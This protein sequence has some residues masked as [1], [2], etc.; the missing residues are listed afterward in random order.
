M[1]FPVVLKL[2]SETITHKSDVGGVKLNLKNAKEVATAYLEIEE[3]VSKLAGAEHFDGVTVQ[4]MVNRGS[5]YE[6]ILGSSTDPQFGP[7]LLFGTGGQLVEIFKDSALAIPPLTSTLALRMMEKT[8]IFEALHGVR[9]RKPVDISAL[10]NILIDFSRMVV[11]N[12][13][14]KECDINP[15]FVS[16]NEIIALDARV[17]L[18]ESD[19]TDDDLPQLAIRPYPLHHVLNASLKD[20]TPIIL[21]PIRPEDEP[22]IV[23]FHR[24][25]SENSVRQR[26]FEFMS[27]DERVA[28]ERLIRICFTDYDREWTL[29]AEIEGKEASQIIGVGRL[30]LVPGTRYAHFALII[31][32]NYHNLGLGTCLLQHLMTIAKQENIEMI[33]ARILSENVNMI[34]LC[35]QLGFTLS[36]D[37]DPYVTRAQWKVC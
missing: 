37:T 30:F 25:L 8:R 20:G 18:H 29:V 24:E 9:G 19:V 15:L 32:D 3:S 26:Y 35:R 27:L 21:R 28:H 33:D 7:V 22:L 23:A 34:K 4:R 12:R 13:R 14:I 6:L 1:G 16:E 36:P 2:S 17:V 31:V 10:E 11:E 5:G